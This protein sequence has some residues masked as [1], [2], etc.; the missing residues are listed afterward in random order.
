M[1]RISSKPTRLNEINALVER[2]IPNRWDIVAFLLI[3]S[4]FALFAIGIH[5]TLAPVSVLDKQAIT[6]DWQNLPE[7]AMRTTL[8]MLFALLASFI[9]TFVYGTLAAKSRRAEKILIPILD[10]LQSVPVLGFISIT[11]VFFL[12]IAPGRV[13]GPELVAMFALFTSQAWNMTFSFYQSLRTV[14]RDLLE[15]ARAFHLT[16]WQRFWKLEVP[17]SMPGLVWNTMMSMSGGWFFVVAAEAIAV[18]DHQVNLP[19]IGSYLALAIA[20]GNLVAVG[21][22]VVTMAIVI[23]L[24][25]Q[26][27]FRPIVAWVDK[28]RLDNTANQVA[29]KS[30]LLDMVRQTRIIQKLLTPIVW[31]FSSLARIPLRFPK[32]LTFRRHATDV[33]LLYNNLKILSKKKTRIWRSHVI[34]IIWDIVLIFAMLYLLWQGYL[35]IAEKLTINDVLHVFWLGSLTMVRVIVL[36]IIATIIWVPIGV[37]IGLRPNIAG[38]VQ[39][40]VQML[41]AFPANV[42]FPAIIAV[43]A[44]YQLNPNIW[45]SLLMILGA[46]WYILFNVIAGA[47]AY[48]NDFREVVLN[49]RIKG[50]QWW[51]TAILPGIFPY[52]ITGAITAT[53]GAWNAS[54]VAEAVSWGNVQLYANGLGSY[55]SQHT[56]AG[57]F[58]N[59]LL[60]V[61]V[62]CLF[63]TF[64]NRLFWRPI[65]AW[66]EAKLR[67]D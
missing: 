6:L 12:S 20:Q 41:A 51:R 34:D 43:I 63:V 60:G 31:F 37:Y 40:I 42:L 29:P 52:Y 46:Q 33:A 2:L 64:F 53:G 14:P 17:F 13:L 21:Y 11:V 15:V 23:L 44:Y 61:S 50:W 39:P 25:D 49:F 38:K 47:A 9:F 65:Y 62:M 7:Y 3:F 67:F 36:L 56:E 30:W 18:G 19:G 32:S 8:R 28:F 48:P 58:P 24:Y 35:Y 4:L 26:L 1:R 45:L 66:A 22:V 57:N 54:I 59:I 10:I 5:Q 27:L 55:I 16:S